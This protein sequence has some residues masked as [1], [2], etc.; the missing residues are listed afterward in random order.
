MTEKSF[1]DSNVLIYA[2]DNAAPGKRDVARALV[3]ELLRDGRGVIS[4]QVLQEF[5]AVT[6]GKRILAPLDAKVALQG[7]REFESV[8][9]SPD[10][11]EEAVDCSLLNRISFWDA[12]IITAAVAANCSTALTEDLQ[13]GQTILGVRI[14]NPFLP[15]KASRPSK[16]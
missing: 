13:H 10:L 4:T 1:V 11:I 3:H 6:T 16:H 8:Q 12:L 14:V 9:V 7:F 15:A 5:Y 2:Y